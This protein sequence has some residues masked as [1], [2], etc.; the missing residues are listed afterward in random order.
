MDALSLAITAG[1]LLLYS[2]ISGRLQGT[3]ITAPLAFIVFGL[4]IGAGGLNVADI[5]P[6]H[7]TIHF[8]A[9]FT[10]ILVLFTDAARIDLDQVRRDHNLPSRMLIVGLPLAIVAG[11]VVAS[12]L[13]P[14]FSL[15]EAALLAALLAPTDAALGQSVISEKAVPVRIRQAINIESGLNDGIALPVVFLLAA[16]AGT[17]PGATEAGEWVRFGLL[18]VVL[19]PLAGV[20]VGYVGARALDSAIERGWANTAFQGIGILSLAVFTYVAAELVGGNGFIAAFVGGMVFGNTIRHPCTFLFEFMESEGQLLM[21]ITFLVFGAAL[22]PEGIAHLNPTNLFYAVLSLTVIRMIPVA[23]SL[24]GSGVRLPTQLFLGWFGPRGLA[25]ILFVLLI[26]EESDVPHR[27]QLLSIT[28]ITVALSALLHGVSA[29]PLARIFGRLADRMG[30]C[31][32][33]RV[34]AEMPTREGHIQ[35]GNNQERT[36]N[37]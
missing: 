2:L 7:S 28:V 11:T 15:W 6:G 35:V 9:E 16:L 25:S 33:T 14:A 8:I 26:L 5:D 10:L 27:E 23:V 32:E 1:G 22:L 19:G 18:Q 31:E 13:F 17:A 21:L 12:Q 24:I 36:V 4:I 30:E 20:G 29:A 34:V 3:I 37:Q